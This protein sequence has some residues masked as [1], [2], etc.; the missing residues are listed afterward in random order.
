MLQKGRKVLSKIIYMDQTGLMFVC[1]IGEN[2]RVLYDNMS[3]QRGMPGLLLSID[4]EKA[5]G[6]IAHYFLFKCLIP[7]P[8]P[9]PFL[10]DGYVPSTQIVSFMVLCGSKRTVY[11]MV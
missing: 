6:S 5:F 7:P 1:S 10:R 4:P 8:P 3:E 2:I 11:R 9:P